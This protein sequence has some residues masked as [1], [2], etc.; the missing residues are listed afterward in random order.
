MASDLGKMLLPVLAS[1]ESYTWLVYANH[2]V[3]GTKQGQECNSD[4]LVKQNYGVSSIT[5]PNFM[6]WEESASSLKENDRHG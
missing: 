4:P 5:W 6:V 2:S 1:C 3:I